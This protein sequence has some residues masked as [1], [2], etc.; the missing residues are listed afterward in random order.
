[1]KNHCRVTKIITLSYPLPDIDI[2]EVVEPV[3]SMLYSFRTPVLEKSGE[4]FQAWSCLLK[5]LTKPVP[6]C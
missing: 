3:L 5:T 4:I 2:A 1:M 6:T